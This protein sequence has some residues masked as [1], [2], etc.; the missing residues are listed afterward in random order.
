MFESSCKA[1]VLKEVID[2]TST[3]VDEAKF[4]LDDEGV[5]IKAVDPAH[6]AMIQLRLRKGAFDEYEAGEGEIG[7]DLAKLKDVLKLSSTGDDVRIVHDEDNHQLVITI[8]NLERR[9]SLVDTAGMSEP[10]EPNLEL[11]AK[12]VVES[13]EL[14]R[15]VK[16]SL[17]VSD[18]VALIANDDGFQLLAEGEMDTVDLDIA[19]SSLKELNV[20]ERAKS[21]FSLDY[22]ESM[23]DAAKASE[24]V[25]LRMGTDYPV[26]MTFQI[27]EGH[28]DVEYLLA[29][30]IESE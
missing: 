28:G 1:E 19:K 14:A 24:F 9:M 8:G 6:V 27:A 13:G 3:L 18:H 4:V 21:L 23:L 26:K 7:V 15:G 5:S 25:T 30:R 16:A 29:P 20:D 17:A 11:P 10:K 2:A 12:V 22:L